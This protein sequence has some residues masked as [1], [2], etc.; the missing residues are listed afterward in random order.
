MSFITAALENISP[1][2]CILVILVL[3]SVPRSSNQFEMLYNIFSFLSKIIADGCYHA[4]FGALSHIPGPFLAKFSS[5]WIIL[6]CRFARRSESVLQQHRRHGNVVRIAPNNISFASRLALETIYGHKSG[7]IKGPFYE[8][9]S[10]FLLH[11]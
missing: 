3:V 7:F 5:L 6:Q 1:V 4:L 11:A 2:V 10:I 9:M 8:D